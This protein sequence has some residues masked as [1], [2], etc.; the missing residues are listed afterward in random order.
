LSRSPTPSLA[1]PL[2]PR[3]HRGTGRLVLLL[4]LSARTSPCKPRAEPAR[5][6][7][8]GCAPSTSSLVIATCS[9][10]WLRHPWI[11]RRFGNTGVRLG[12]PAKKAP[13]CE[14]G[15]T[16][17]RHGD[18]SSQNGGKPAAPR[19]PTRRQRLMCARQIWLR[20]GVLS[21][22]HRRGLAGAGEQ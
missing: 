1:Q 22:Y 13:P 20:C 7:L 5:A 6:W 2:S 11:L 4:H 21:Q 9:A 17:R 16:R 12:I 15:A 8:S 19:P 14:G 10:R 3:R 18:D